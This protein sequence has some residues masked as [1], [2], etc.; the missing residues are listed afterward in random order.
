MTGACGFGFSLCMEMGKEISELKTQKQMLLYIIGEISYLH[1]PLEE[2]FDILTERMEAPFD[3]FLGKVSEKMK[4]RSG[5]NLNNIWNEEIAAL[6]LD[7][8]IS[9]RTNTYLKRMADCFECEG[10]RI[11]VET[12]ELLSRELEQEIEALV[13][14]KR[15][16]GRL[17]RA[18]SALTG[19]MCIVLF[20]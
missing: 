11:Q 2:I 15:E 7:Y 14:R 13:E 20:L 4:S 17:I 18:L 12:L 5:R 16:N 1:R 8:G 6:K 10:D 9:K 3:I 19:I